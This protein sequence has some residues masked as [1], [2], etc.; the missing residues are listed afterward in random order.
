MQCA[1]RK[2]FV[3][4]V[5]RAEIQRAFRVPHLCNNFKPSLRRSALHLRSHTTQARMEALPPAKRQCIA[6]AGEDTLVLQEPSVQNELESAQTEPESVP[7][8]PDQGAS[9]PEQKRQGDKV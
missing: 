2:S 4:L 8:A 5:T 3:G 9:K 7:A 6:A 1:L